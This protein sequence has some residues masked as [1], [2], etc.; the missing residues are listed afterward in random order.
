MGYYWSGKQKILQKGGAK[1]SWLLS[2]L[3]LEIQVLK[4]TQKNSTDQQVNSNLQQQM[5]GL[6]KDYTDYSKA[7]SAILAEENA[8]SYGLPD[9][10]YKLSDLDQLIAKLE[11]QV[12]QL[13]AV[14]MDALQSIEKK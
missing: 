13:K 4:E 6:A 12:E 5:E 2:L 9:K 3:M 1:S 8:E 14:K 11:E 7:Y 10:A